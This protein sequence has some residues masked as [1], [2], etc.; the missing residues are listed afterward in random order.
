[1]IEKI[2]FRLLW[3][4][5]SIPYFNKIAISFYLRYGANRRNNNK[6]SEKSIIV[7][8]EPRLERIVKALEKRN[9]NVLILGRG[10][11]DYLFKKHLSNYIKNNKGNFGEYT[12][13]VYLN[14]KKERKKYLNDCVFITNLLKR[15]FPEISNIVL[16]KYNDDYTLELVEAFQVSKWTTIVYDREGTVTKRRLETIPP[17]IAKQA[18]TCDYIIT[19][20]E[21]HKN[22]FENVF[23]F[24]GLP[25]PEI[26]IMGNPLSDEWFNNGELIDSNIRDKK[27]IG[28]NILFF[29]FGEFSYIY[30][31][32]YLNGK[33][34]VWRDFLTDIH[35]MLEEHLINNEND[36]IHYKR[37]PKGNRDYWAGSENLIGH[38]NAQLLDNTAN[39]NILITEND[40]II[41]FQTTALIDAMHTEKI[42]IY[43]G[44]VVNYQ[45]LKKDLIPFDVYAKQGALLHAKS[46]DDLKR[47]LLLNPEEIPINLD[48]RKKIRESFTSN[49]D[50]RVAEK[51]AEWL[52]EVPLSSS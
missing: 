37:G 51:F 14:Y 29:A 36:S 33:D 20:N 11:F 23:S 34:E 25:S 30:D 8:Y 50:G 28:R 12:L 39:S 35:H 21:I 45:E 22:F 42:I 2:Y 4:C 46:P 16:P 40:F 24:A 38:P 7:L 1:M 19:Y 15:K 5:F 9:L 13:S 43:C 17:I 6:N 49:P 10:I 48:A 52:H 3:L 31:A 26:L 32:E 44:W 27:E 41:A 47:F 18:T